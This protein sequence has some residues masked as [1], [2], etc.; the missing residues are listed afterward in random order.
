VGSFIENLFSCPEDKAM[1]SGSIATMVILL[2]AFIAAA[3]WGQVDLPKELATIIPT[4]P[5]SKVV[6]A[7]DINGGAQT[8]METQDNSKAVMVFYRKAMVYRGWDIMT[9]M[10]L[11]SGS[12]LIFSKEDQALHITATGSK[13]GKTIILVNL[14]K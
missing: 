5:G 10:A 11:E 12:T 7:K 6:A 8:I 9:G 1:K 4:Y 2:T 14:S 13:E 3:A